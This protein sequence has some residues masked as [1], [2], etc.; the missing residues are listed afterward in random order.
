MKSYNDLPADLTY[1]FFNLI[2]DIQN[3]IEASNNLFLDSIK[4]DSKY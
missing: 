1:Y 4:S 3:G 2:I